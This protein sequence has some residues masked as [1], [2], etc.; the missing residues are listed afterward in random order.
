M[1]LLGKKNLF[2][3]GISDDFIRTMAKEK[4]KKNQTL[5]RLKCFAFQKTP[6]RRE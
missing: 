2:D 4:K 3:L 6:L 1:K 5:S